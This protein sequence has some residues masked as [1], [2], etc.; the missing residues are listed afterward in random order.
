MKL[1]ATVALL[2]LLAIASPVFAQSPAETDEQRAEALYE[3]ANDLAV[4]GRLRDALQVLEEAL[5]IF[6]RIY[7]ADDVRLAEPL[8]FTGN[9][10]SDLGNL[11][12]GLEVELRALAIARAKLGEYDVLTAEILNNI[13]GLYRR[14]GEYGKAIPMLEQAIEIRECQ[15]DSE[16]EIVAQS[17][18]NLGVV[19]LSIGDYA[20]AAPMLVRSR[21][22]IA[23]VFGE[24]NYNTGRATGVLANLYVGLGDYATA[25]PLLRR[26]LE[27]NERDP[28]IGPSHPM[29]LIALHNLATYYMTIGAFDQAEPLFVRAIELREKAVG[30][31]SPD[32]AQ[33]LTNLGSLY[34]IMGQPDRARPLFERAMGIFERSVGPDSERLAS[35]VRRLGVLELGQDNFDRARTYFERTLAIYEKRIGPDHP[36]TAEALALLGTLYMRQGKLEAARPY[37]ERALAIRERALGVDHPFTASTQSAWAQYL[38]AV[39]ETSRAVAEQA[40]ANDARER[41]LVR[42]LTVG[43]EQRKLS[44]LQLTASELDKTISLHQSGA[45]SD[46]MAARTALEVILRRKGRALDA[47]TRQIEVLRNRATQEDRKL[48]SDLAIARAE[49][50]RRTLDS[51]NPQAVESTPEELAALERRLQDLET[52]VADRGAEFRAGLLPVTLDAVREGIPDGAVLVEIASYRPFDPS[53]QR[54]GAARYTAYTLDRA[55]TVRW[56]DLGPVTEIDALVTDLRR[57][58]RSDADEAAAKRAGRALDE[59][60]MR[61]VR[62]LIG[63]GAERLLVSP[64]GAL[65][66][67][68]FAALV[69]ENGKYLVERYDIV[70]LTSGRD[71]LRLRRAPSAGVEPRQPE[72]V[73]NPDF[74]T[75]PDHAD[76]SIRFLPLPGTAAEAKAISRLL[77]GAKVLTGANATESAIKSVKSPKILHIATHG[78]FLGGVTADATQARVRA[79]WEATRDVVQASDWKASAPGS[80][81]ESERDPLLRS[82]L[83]LAGANVRKGGDGDDGLLTALEA[84]GLN[85]EGTELVVLSAC[86]TGVGEVRAGDGVYGLRRALTLAGAQAQL[87]SL[88]AVSDRATRELMVAYYRELL[89]GHG[90]S[91]ALRRTQLAFLRD[92]R[93]R[94]PFYWASFIPSGAWWPLD[95][96]AAEKSKS[97]R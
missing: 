1:R 78:F 79:A 26:A 72:V 67:V 5:P 20:T 37:L 19:Y 18:A 80:V 82:G 73:A 28:H 53:A 8:H 93:H 88:W 56:A 2:L 61:P 47:M 16:S 51:S 30:M 17:L 64:D 41:E 36:N 70:Y 60:V 57:Q 89:S 45:P 27:I 12:G 71:L 66:L 3:K 58:L 65:N 14:L 4:A 31:D 81:I 34:D 95:S 35:A 22:I 48:L 97:H 83:G 63:D 43:S 25:E 87:S 13:G 52:R 85:L 38:W 33:S 96:P 74:G 40:K 91:E 6:E 69:D 77:P 42:N 24:E 29:A 75:A 21:R 10:R 84:A 92:P 49:Y 39:G 50:A 55:G 46:A 7:P 86:D 76:P 54:Y 23:R 59:R 90:R 32:L 68:P 15:Y 62:A 9:L 11:Q 44:Y 94:H